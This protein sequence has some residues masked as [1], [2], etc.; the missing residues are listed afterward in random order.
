MGMCAV[1]ICCPP[2]CAGAS[3]AASVPACCCP[4]WLIHPAWLLS[5]TVALVS[6][7]GIYLALTFQ[8]QAVSGP[9]L[10]NEPVPGTGVW[11]DGGTGF[12]ELGTAETTWWPPE[13]SA[14]DGQ[15]L[16][17]ATLKDLGRG[18]VAW[19]PSPLAYEGGPCWSEGNSQF[20]MQGFGASVLMAGGASML[21]V[22]AI[23][24]AVKRNGGTCCGRLIERPKAPEQERE[25]QVG[26]GA[27]ADP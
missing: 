27:E 14:R 2:L 18:T 13:G 1:T 26:I 7:L 20:F 5:A 4:W 8:C 19:S 12:T 15:V 25:L 3:V 24:F 6:G 23:V 22:S 10:G 21:L 11:V 17:N 16:V 9:W